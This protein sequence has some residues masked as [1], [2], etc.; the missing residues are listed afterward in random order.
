MM[1][2]SKSISA[3]VMD[4]TVGCGNIM[5]TPIR[6]TVGADDMEVRADI[7]EAVGAITTTA[8]TTI[9]TVTATEIGTTVIET[10]TAIET[11]TTIETAITKAITTTIEPH[12]AHIRSGPRT[13]LLGPFLFVGVVSE[14][15]QASAAKRLMI[16]SRA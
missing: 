12:V 4:G 16:F 7:M 15:S 9:M 10:A 6:N 2:S 14:K 11:V 8:T 5:A 3:I 1:V 13:S